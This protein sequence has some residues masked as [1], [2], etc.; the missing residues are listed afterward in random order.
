MQCILRML[1]L[2]PISVFS[3]SNLKSIFGQIWRGKV[4]VFCFD[5]KLKDTHTHSCTRTHTHTYTHTNTHSV[6][7]MLILIST[8][9]FSNFKSKYVRY[10]FLFFEIPNLNP[11]FR[12]IWVEK[13]E[14]SFLTGRLYTEYLEDV[15]I[16]IQS[17]VQKG[18]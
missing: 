7:E 18:R 16:R 13:V 4:K 1:I 14:F 10:W 3:I 11:F 6:S 17:K 2:I 15:I 12:Q 5:W 9:V 8:L